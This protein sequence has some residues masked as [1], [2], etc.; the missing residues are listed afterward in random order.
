MECTTLRVN[1]N[2]NSGLGVIR[3][4]QSRFINY[5]KQSTLLGDVESKVASA[6]VGKR[7]M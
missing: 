6:Y 7:D 2:V 4:Y 3:R 5:N 1:L